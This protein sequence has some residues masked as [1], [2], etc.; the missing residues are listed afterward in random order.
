[1][2]NY[3]LTLIVD[4]KLKAE[5]QKILLAKI[6]K[7]VTDAKGKVTSQDE[8]GK[9]ELGYPINKKNLGIYFCWQLSLLPAALAG[10]DRKL[11]TEDS[12]M[13]YLFIKKEKPASPKRKAMVD[14]KNG[15]K[16]AK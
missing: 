9:K 5:D 7:L 14:K 4:P 2:R 3:E 1:M 8:W 16:V 13:R 12:V 10:V 11:K 6:A 15:P